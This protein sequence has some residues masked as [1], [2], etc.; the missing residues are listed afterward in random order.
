V[1]WYRAHWYA[2]GGLA[3]AAA[4]CLAWLL[5][6]ERL[7]PYDG[8]KGTP[9]A[10]VYVQHED[11]VTIWSGDPLSQADRIRLE[12]APE[13]FDHVSVF[14]MQT[15]GPLVLLYAGRLTPHQ[16]ALLPKAWQLD[17]SPEAEQLVVMF[18]HAEIST[19]AAQ[20]LLRAHDPDDVWVLRLTLP[21]HVSK[22]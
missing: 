17:A 6:R 16:R 1:P 21:K 13:K 10:I 20:V 4:V 22:P 15:D 9:A 12:V 11:Q 7:A 19:S 2:L 3:V 14:H 18:A 5:P 8:V